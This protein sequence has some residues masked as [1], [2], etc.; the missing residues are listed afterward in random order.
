MLG[1][2]YSAIGWGLGMTD[3]LAFPQSGASLSLAYG[4]PGGETDTAFAEAL[5]TG[6]ANSGQVLDQP[7]HISVKCHSKLVS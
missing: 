3:K 2:S 6:V 7:W 4:N 1:R 5:M